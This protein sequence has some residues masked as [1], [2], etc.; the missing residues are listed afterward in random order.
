MWF[1]SAWGLVWILLFH[2]CW[3]CIPCMASSSH[4]HVM[5]MSPVF[6]FSFCFFTVLNDVAFAQI[7]YRSARA[8]YWIARN[9]C[10]ALMTCRD[11]R[12][13]TCALKNHLNWQTQRAVSMIITRSRGYSEWFG[14][15]IKS[16]NVIKISMNYSCAYSKR[17][18]NAYFPYYTG[19]TVFCLFFFDRNN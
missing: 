7:L 6:N 13:N 17:T 8:G 14:R 16:S 9:T 1:L 18:E 11:H 4:G 5:W 12:G 10:G 19:S 3:V 2:T 15:A